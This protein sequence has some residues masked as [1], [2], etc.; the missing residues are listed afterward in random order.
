VKGES[1]KQSS[2]APGLR[3]PAAAAA[4][5]VLLAALIAALVA[6]YSL[7]A[8]SFRRLAAACV[9][10]GGAVFALAAGL[11]MVGKRKYAALTALFA[12]VIGI[13]GVT[14]VTRI[15]TDRDFVRP[16]ESFQRTVAEPAVEELAASLVD[17]STTTELDFPQFLGPERSA[18]VNNVSLAEDWE[19]FPPEPVWRH[20]VCSA[21]SGFS[22]VN[23]TAITMEQR[24]DL[25][26]VTAYDVISGELE[27]MH[28]VEARYENNESGVG[29]RS[30][31]TINDGL[32]YSLGATG[33]LLCLDGA[34]GEVIWRRNLLDEY[35]I[36][37]EEERRTVPYGR[38]AS[39][40][41]VGDLV[42]V[43]AGGPEEGRRVSLVAY[44][45]K[46][47]ELVWEGG[48]EQVSHSSPAYA[49]LL[50]VPQIIIVNED[51]V[52]GH[53]AGTGKVLW[54]QGWAGTTYG[55]PSVSQPVALPPNR[56]FLSK[57]YGVG[58]GLYELTPTG[59]GT[60]SSKQIWQ[61]YRVMRTMF[62]NV[63]V[64]DGYVYGLSDGIL[65]SIDLETGS[66]M[67]KGGRYGHGQIL[68]VGDVILVLTEDG[69]LVMVRAAPDAANEVL[70]RF[71]VLDGT[72]W[73][74]FALYGSY[75][76]VRNAQEA[77][78]YKLEETILNDVAIA[79]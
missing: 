57:S 7:D 20:P 72:T 51:S 62:T 69:E 21:W 34:D 23:G 38:S 63:V 32:V 1:F 55:N 39:P 31:P 52:T 43:P 77:A 61:S 17:L 37:A 30:T 5:A 78:A 26:V 25:E 24:R 14:A 60:F 11:F 59:D 36:S 12:V 46:T 16:D 6:A 53:D 49:T 41:I 2:P 3:V 58:S 10:G 15:Q 67:W 64:K 66:R 65:E 29:P 76:L 71:H 35:D 28:A 75:V 13:A 9:V 27:W 40:L 22:I 56:V 68:L 4:A 44:H 79:H 8:L 47:G 19:R 54:R 18:V 73:N 50:G 45:K 48:N 74:T 70:G 33:W 42:I